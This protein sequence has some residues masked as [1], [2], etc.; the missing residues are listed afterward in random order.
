M[1]Y[2]VSEMPNAQSLFIRRGPHRRQQNLP[3]PHRSR[4]F[5]LFGGV[6]DLLDFRGQHLTISSLP[7]TRWFRASDIY[8][9]MATQLEAML[10]HSR[11]WLFQ[12]PRRPPKT[13]GSVP[14]V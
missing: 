5:R 8:S 14:E 4:L 10:Q 6:L 12:V 11:V 3:N 7:R 1:H 9:R 13:K 2:K